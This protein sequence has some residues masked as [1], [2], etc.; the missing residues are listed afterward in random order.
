[1]GPRDQVRSKAVAQERRK[2][3][4]RVL[5][6]RNEEIMHIHDE[7]IAGSGVRSVEV[8]TWLVH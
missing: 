2:D 6:T 7:F 5:R 8:V 4:Y 1:M 3:G